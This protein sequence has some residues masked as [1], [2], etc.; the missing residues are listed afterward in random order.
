MSIDDLEINLDNANGIASAQLFLRRGMQV[1]KGRNGTGKGE[2]IRAVEKAGGAKVPCAV[3]D[4]KERGKITAYREGR[5]VTTISLGRAVRTR[6]E[7]GET[8]ISLADVGPFG[9]FVSPGFEAPG[10]CAKARVKALLELTGQ[11]ID[12]AALDL[13]TAEAPSYR[14]FIEEWIHAKSCED[15]VEAAGHLGREV[16]RDAAEQEKKAAAALGGETDAADRVRALL[17]DHFENNPAKVPDLE[18]QPA[19][20]RV[21]DLQRDLA[22]AE[23]SAK[24]RAALLAQQQKLKENR[25]ARPNTE[26]A[27]EI[28][29]EAVKLQGIAANDVTEAT[30]ILEQAKSAKC[31]ADIREQQARDSFSDAEKTARGWDSDEEILTREPS[32]ARAADV[33]AVRN[34]LEQSQTLATLARHADD[35]RAEQARAT[36]RGL[37][38]NE[39]EKRA[40]E[41]RE[42]A[43]G[44]P[45][46]LGRIL[47]ASGVDNIQVEMIKPS[48]RSDKKEMRLFSHID[49]K[50]REWETRMS[51]GQKMKVAIQIA[52]R[53]YEPDQ[54]LAIPAELWLSLDGEGK[55]MTHELLLEHGLVGISEEP[56]DGTECGVRY[57]SDPDADLV[58]W[59]EPEA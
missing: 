23:E 50:R 3:S 10:A 26:R 1:L 58:P 7:P 35:L 24:G 5:P 41:L 39:A 31:I 36:E 17:R 15:L 54:V 44:I 37:A 40:K 48:S 57:L 56:S 28:L 46:Q 9:K 52:A 45:L 51:P 2:T 16:H 55:T 25:K 11:Q 8:E 49:G 12:A 42:A 33:E 18:F 14:E 32:G 34:L 47:E 21:A 38:R 6:N 19:T 30:Q 29:K 59:I 20:E 13:L 4:G 27:M 53:H 43:W 22:V